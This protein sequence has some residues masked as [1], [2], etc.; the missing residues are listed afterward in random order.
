MDLDD[1]AAGRPPWKKLCTTGD[2]LARSNHAAVVYGNE[3]F[4]FGGVVGRNPGRDVADLEI[5]NFDTLCWARHHDSGTGPSPRQ[6]P[7]LVL[8]EGS[9]FACLV[10][11]GGYDRAKKFNDIFCFD[12]TTYA[13]RQTALQETN[14]TSPPPMTDHCAVMVDGSMVVFGGIHRQ[15]ADQQDISLVWRLKLDHLSNKAVWERVECAGEAP[16]NCTSHAAI[17]IG[18]LML[19]AGGL[20]NW[21]M[22]PLQL[23]ALD[24][25]SRCWSTFGQP[26]PDFGVCRHAAV[27]ADGFF[28]IFGGHS[29]DGHSN[30]LLRIPLAELMTHSAGNHIAKEGAK[31]KALETSSHPL[32]AMDMFKVEQTPLTLADLPPEA[33]RGKSSRQLIRILHSAAVARH[34]D[35]YIDPE[36]GY[37]AFTKIFLERRDCCGNGCRHCP[38]GHVNVPKKNDSAQ[39][40]ATSLDAGLDW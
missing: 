11:F 14:G 23:H 33:V 19:V 29:R 6:N 15:V 22:V 25:R 13:W 10:A 12:L 16:M 4:V 20:R 32:T 17:S 38:W 28:V 35:M 36:S 26:C 9:S 7:T 8:Y 2:A 3:L 24:L 39:Q 21:A 1:L 40:A 30:D 34:L 31:E 18:H 27:F 37:P 5:L